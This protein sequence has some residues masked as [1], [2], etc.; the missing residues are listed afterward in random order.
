MTDAMSVEDGWH[1]AYGAA[2]Q[3]AAA[4]LLGVT[5]GL[6]IYS[7]RSVVSSGERPETWIVSMFRSSSSSEKN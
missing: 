1:A 4:V 2:A 7:G 6:G 3:H 5:R